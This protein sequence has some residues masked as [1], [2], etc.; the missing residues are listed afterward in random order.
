MCSLLPSSCHGADRERGECS[1]VSASDHWTAQAVPTDPLPW[2]RCPS[3]RDTHPS[4]RESEGHVVHVH[5][6]KTCGIYWSFLCCTVPMRCNQTK[7]VLPAVA[8]SLVPR[9]IVY[10]TYIQCHVFDDP[11]DRVLEYRRLHFLQFCFQISKFLLFVKTIYADLPKTMTTLLEPGEGGA[12]EEA[13]K[14]ASVSE[15][16]TRVF[17]WPCLLLSSFLPS[18]LSLKTCTIVMRINQ[19]VCVCVCVCVYCCRILFQ[20]RPHHSKYWQSYPSL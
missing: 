10:I 13:S 9:E 16:H 19:C 8:C 6:D 18:H 2:G 15:T 1:G 20:G 7:T 17:I 12:V 14:T 3:N 5:R 4:S 11:V